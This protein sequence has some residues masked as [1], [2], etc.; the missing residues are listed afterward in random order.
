M[1]AIIKSMAAPDVIQVATGE[2]TERFNA[3][4]TG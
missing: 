4:F 2:I 3:I 1:A